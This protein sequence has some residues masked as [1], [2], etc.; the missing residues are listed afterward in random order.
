MMEAVDPHLDNF[1]DVYNFDT[2][3]DFARNAMRAFSE[4][5]RRFTEV[6]LVKVMA[7]TEV[8]SHQY[9]KAGA[10]SRLHPAADGLD[11]WQII[12]EQQAVP[13]VQ[14]R[15]AWTGPPVIGF[16]GYILGGTGVAQEQE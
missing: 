6:P 5:F 4:G 2:I 15:E 14:P 9:A 11:Y 8:E 3:S 13:S 1:P 7:E 16:R 10:L 12:E